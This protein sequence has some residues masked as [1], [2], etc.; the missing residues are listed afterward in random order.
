MAGKKKDKA[1]TFRQDLMRGEHELGTTTTAVQDPPPNGIAKPAP[2]NPNDG[3]LM[4]LSSHPRYYEQKSAA[5]AA[6]GHALTNEEFERDYLQ[7]PEDSKIISGTSI[8]DPVLAELAYRWFCPLGGVVFDPF[9]G[10]SVRGI[11]ASKLGRRYTG[12]DLSERQLEANREQAAEMHCSPMPVWISGDARQARALCPGLEADFILSCPPYGALERYSDDPRDLSTMTWDGFVTAL[13]VA[14][15]NA[16]AM[17]RPDRFACFVVGDIRDG[18]GFYRG[19]PAATTAA[20]EACGAHLYNDAILVTVPGSMP[21]R[22][23]KQFEGSR[24]LGKTH[25]NVLVFCNGDPKNATAAV[26]AVEFDS[27]VFNDVIEPGAAE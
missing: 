14:V 4:S 27:S 21:V 5:E 2:V 1:R 12:I 7:M 16:C 23:G 26:G 25:Q 13:R 17:L 19:L 15:A 18:D 22:V 10:G 11:V 20:F 3:L 8:F 24:K 6:I 9:A